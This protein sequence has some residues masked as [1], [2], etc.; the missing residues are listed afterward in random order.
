MQLPTRAMQ[1]HTK[2]I[3]TNLHR[4]TNTKAAQV[5]QKAAVQ[6]RNVMTQATA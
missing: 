1:T 5:M 2:Q 6:Q 4:D 3:D